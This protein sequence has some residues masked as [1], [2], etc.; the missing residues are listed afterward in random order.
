MVRHKLKQFHGQITQ[1][2]VENCLTRNPI[3]IA[4]KVSEAIT[5]L[6]NYLSAWYVKQAGLKVGKGQR[7]CYVGSAH[8]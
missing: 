5:L 8:D 3:N 7:H 6:S 2:A 4:K 1:I